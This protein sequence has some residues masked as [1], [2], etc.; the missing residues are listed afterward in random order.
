MM[1]ISLVAILALAGLALDSGSLYRARLALQ[2]AADAA[3]LD[4]LNYTIKTGAAEIVKR[5]AA[6]SINDADAI[7]SYLERK[8]R[9]T[10]RVNL[11][12][13]GY[14]DLKN[15]PTVAVKGT[16][17]PPTLYVSDDKIVFEYQVE[18]SR[19]IDFVIMDLLPYFGQGGRT[20]TVSARATRNRVNLALLL[21]TS[22]SMN[23]PEAG[24]CSCINDNSCGSASGRKIDVLADAVKNFLLMFDKKDQILFV[25]FNMAASDPS[26]FDDLQKD[27]GIDFYNASQEQIDAFISYMFSLWQPSSNTNICDALIQAYN[28]MQAIASESQ[29]AYML[30]SD[31]APTAGR[32][33]FSNAAVLNKNL[34]PWTYQS[35]GGQFDYTHYTMRWKPGSGGGTTYPGPSVL[36]QSG[37]VGFGFKG[38]LPP[39]LGTYDAAADQASF[40]NDS[41][42]GCGPDSAPEVTAQSDLGAAATEVFSPCL[43]SLEAHLPGKASD[44]YG[45]NYSGA[46][47]FVRWPEQYYNCAIELAD[48]IRGRKGILY[49]IGLGDK[50]PA[51]SDPDDPYQNA[52]DTTYRK[53]HFLARVANDY[54]AAISFSNSASSSDPTPPSFAYDDESKRG[55][56]GYADYKDSSLSK[57]E[58]RGKYLATSNINE[59]RLL[60]EL[61]ARK[62]NLKLSS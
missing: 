38:P 15:G 62:I 59:L 40:P 32:F 7:S 47:G 53:D 48:F 45:G 17:Y 21:D 16:F 42:K 3:A 35:S 61:I 14:P 26:T 54:A 24:A 11:N 55:Y 36:V 25:P 2:T 34:E 28:G 51:P 12:R 29:A 18:L 20:L 56:V 41:T 22:N 23:C 49:V 58:K 60:F 4:G 10:V 31:G 9:H 27:W 33:L 13:A 52:G 37:M 30:F 39:P 43:D 5:A 57:V 44:T 46:A 6:S 1:V 8:S 19:R 50:D